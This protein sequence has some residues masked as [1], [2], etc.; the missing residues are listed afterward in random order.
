MLI[1]KKII[2]IFIFLML[3]FLINSILKFGL[4]PYNSNSKKIWKNYFI[5]EKID[6]LFIGS[7]IGNSFKEEIIDDRLGSF[8]LNMSSN[9]QAYDQN[10]VVIKEVIKKHKIKKIILGFGY[11]T[12]EQKY[13]IKREMAFEKNKNYGLSIDERILNNLNFIFSSEHIKKPESINYIFEWIYNSVPFSVTQI[14][15]NIK[16]KIKS[17]TNLITNENEADNYIDYNNVGNQISSKIYFRKPTI[18]SENELRKIVKLC[19]DNKIE[20]IVINTPHPV[21]DILCYGEDYFT[22]G[23]QTKEFFKNLDVPYYDFNLIKPSIFKSE[24]D[25][26]FDFEH[27]NR[28]GEIEFSKSFA[29]FIK[30][31]ESNGDMSKYFYTPEE[32]L[33]SIKHISIVN[34]DTKSNKEGINIVAKA[35]TGSKVNVEYEILVYDDI[36]KEYKVMRE[37]DKNPTYFYHISENKKIKIR[38][39]ARQIG[40]NIPYERYYE[41]EIVFKK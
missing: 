18:E 22:L 30:L 5:K 3:I 32:Y 13:N 27:M 35:Y 36:L 31:R 20:F 7:S 10:Y 14:I 33:A 29:K 40:T 41:K 34:F 21:Y 1:F 2:K 6:T 4:I 17:D 23:E 9:G 25:Y 38:V 8:S 24:E 19:K 16:Y 26:F 12:L 39:N 28:K 37:Y 15:N 11:F